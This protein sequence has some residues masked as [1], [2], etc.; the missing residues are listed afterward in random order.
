M[1]AQAP[2]SISVSMYQMQSY[3]LHLVKK[4]VE[5]NFHNRFKAMV[6]S[7]YQIK[8][9][10]QSYLLVS[11]SSSP[12]LHTPVFGPLIPALVLNRLLF[13]GPYDEPMR[14]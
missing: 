13:N 2:A 8:M 11:V 3:N 10:N 4:V 14:N 7:G 12:S 1:Y 6:T 9:L 5:M